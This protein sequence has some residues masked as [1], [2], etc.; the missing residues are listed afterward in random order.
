MHLQIFFRHCTKC[1]SF[2]LNGVAHLSNSKS[3]HTSQ[4]TNLVRVINMVETLT[5]DF[6]HV[7]VQ[8]EIHLN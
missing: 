5:F 6:G 7:V 2:C 1:T 3:G 8:V 4:Q